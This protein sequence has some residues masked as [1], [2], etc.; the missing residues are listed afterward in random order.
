MVET[1]MRE[2]YV[3]FDCKHSH[4]EVHVTLFIQSNL[5]RSHDVKG[6]YFR[7]LKTVKQNVKFLEENFGGVVSAV[8]GQQ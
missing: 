4:D 6:L 1:V 7:W 5:R 3:L 8:F 2:S